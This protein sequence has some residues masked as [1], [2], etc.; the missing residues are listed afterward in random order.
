MN[1]IQH[2]LFDLDGTLTDPS[3]GI[4][5][6]LDYA[7]TAM[8]LPSP[9]LIDL[10]QYIGPPLDVAFTDLGIASS[11]I[12]R[13]ISLY[14]DRFVSIGLFENEVYEGIPEMLERLRDTGLDLHVATSK[15]TQFAVRILEHF[16]IASFFEEVVG[17][18]LD[19]SRSHKT[20]VIAHTIRHTGPARSVMIGDRKHDV[21]GA[22]AHGIPAVAVT[23][24]FGSPEELTAANPWH[25]ATSVEQLTEF[26]LTNR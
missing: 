24:G 17:A 3:T 7:L 23:W 22:T 13:A 8:G 2:V 20:D 15:P 19:G 26:L 10:E 16:A 12:P 6:C 21:E 18:T 25:T 11:E 4:T 14:R 1:S 5:R 9:A